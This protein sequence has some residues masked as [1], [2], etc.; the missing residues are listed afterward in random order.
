MKSWTSKVETT[1][2]S[3][4]TWNL[5]LLKNNRIKKNAKKNLAATKAPAANL[6]D[7]ICQFIA[8][9]TRIKKLRKSS[10]FIKKIRKTHKKIILK[11]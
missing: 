2:I 8:A 6:D 10:K 9:A 1:K 5:N 3:F 11:F 7:K 4:L